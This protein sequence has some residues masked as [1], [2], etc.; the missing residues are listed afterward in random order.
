MAE[1]RGAGPGAERPGAARVPPRSLLGAPA[2]AQLT[3]RCRLLIDTHFLQETPLPGRP[4]LYLQLSLD[5]HGDAEDDEA[6][7]QPADEL[8]LIPAAAASG[9]CAALGPRSL[10]TR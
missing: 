1:H 2:A 6:E 10:V 3:A 4:G 8:Y 5:E 9:L 7:D